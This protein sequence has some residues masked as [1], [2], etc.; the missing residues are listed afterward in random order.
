MILPGSVLELRL[1]Y[2]QMLSQS[3]DYVYRDSAGLALFKYVHRLYYTNPSG[4][5][6]T[7][8]DEACS[9]E[10]TLPMQKESEDKI[11]VFLLGTQDS[12]TSTCH[13]RFSI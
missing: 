5:P 3:V 10:Y 7:G 12:R 6:D 8:F 13:L 2:T 4:S 9:I 11:L 1:K